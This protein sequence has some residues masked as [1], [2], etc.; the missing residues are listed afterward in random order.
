[1]NAT[2]GDP[3][4]L[5][6]IVATFSG[7]D[8]ADQAMEALARV[9]RD[10]WVKTADAAVLSRSRDGFVTARDLHETNVLRNTLAG[11]IGGAL[12]GLVGGPAGAAVGG[13]TGAVGAGTAEL[14]RFGLSRQ[15]IDAVSTQLPR[16]SSA[17]VA[18]VEP[19]VANMVMSELQRVEAKI[20]RRLAREA[21]G[22]ELGAAT[23][24]PRRE[25][26]R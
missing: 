25:P 1:M 6:I 26:L 12:I 14:A 5:Q 23:E 19:T 8:T 3:T 20:V 24:Q 16:G 18:A 13:V 2:E 17:I 7:P 21:V 15:E 11:A 9:D 10:G 22:L 4:R